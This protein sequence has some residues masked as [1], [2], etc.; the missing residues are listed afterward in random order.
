MYFFELQAH[1]FMTGAIGHQ[2][3][4]HDPRYADIPSANGVS[5]LG[6]HMSLPVRQ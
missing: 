2:I 6:K 5:V 3:N 1:D 4:R